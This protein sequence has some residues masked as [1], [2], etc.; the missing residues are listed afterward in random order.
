MKAQWEKASEKIAALSQ[1]EKVLVLLTGL[2]IIP[3]IID[4]FLLQPLRDSTALY[5]KQ[6][7]S[8]YSRME[9]YTAQQEELLLEIKNDPAME[10]ERRIEGASKALKATK[11]VLVNYTGT[12]ISPQ[13][14]AIMLESMLHESNGLKLLSLENLAV[15]PL[16]DKESKAQ[17]STVD[18]QSLNDESRNKQ[19]RDVFGL[20]RHGIRMVFQGNYMT[21]MDYLKKLETL[22]WKFYWQNFDYQVE[23]HPKATI[24]LNIYTLS[25]SQWWIGDK[26][27]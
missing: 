13:K 3:G 23:K 19:S 17:K 22:P 8:V 1:R 27:E 16:F 9:S 15:A 11:E 2:I 4:F 10:L 5:N 18:D 21:S 26:D 6:V 12:L 14:M 20:Y 25:T 24:T 7:L